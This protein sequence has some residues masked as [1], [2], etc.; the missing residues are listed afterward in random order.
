MQGTHD[1]YETLTVTYNKLGYGMSR[2]DP[3][4][5]YKKEG[6]GYTLTSTYMD[7]VFGASKTDREVQRRKE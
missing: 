2:A 1:W 5:R 7:D 3:C 6:D 4:V